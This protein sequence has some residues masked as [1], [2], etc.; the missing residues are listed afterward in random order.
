MVYIIFIMQPLALGFIK[1]AFLFFY[2]RIFVF[3]SFQI[4]SLIFVILTVMWMIAFFLGFIFDC[5]LNFSANWGSLASIGENCPFGFEATIAF[6]ITDA[7]FD[8]CIL[9]LPLPWVRT[10][11]VV[12]L[13]Q[14][15]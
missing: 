8:L 14:L 10:I 4:T 5:R 15:Y 1:L 11:N 3:R 12:Q 2:R 6:T 13:W 9:V 7:I